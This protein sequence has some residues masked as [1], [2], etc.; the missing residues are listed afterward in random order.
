MPDFGILSPGTNVVKKSQQDL[1][2]LPG[3]GYVGNSE[4]MKGFPTRKAIGLLLVLFL[5]APPGFCWD[6]CCSTAPASDEHSAQEKSGHDCCAKPSAPAQT[7]TVSCSTSCECPAFVGD[8]LDTPRRI[9]AVSMVESKD[10]NAPFLAL[11]VDSSSTLNRL[12]TCGTRPIE[13]PSRL[14]F[15]SPSSA[16]PRAP[17]AFSS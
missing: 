17:P 6:C 2:R 7:P 10:S 5:V 9:A 4:M 13:S 11:L 16:S 12:T 1:T 8:P 14:S 3:A 15:F